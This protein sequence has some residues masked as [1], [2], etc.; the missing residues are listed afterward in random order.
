MGRLSPV[1]LNLSAPT[2]N[3]EK[4]YEA[5]KNIWLGFEG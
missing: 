2:V 1:T 3:Y 5:I 4:D